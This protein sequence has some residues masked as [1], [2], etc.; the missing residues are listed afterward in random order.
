MSIYYDDKEGIYKH[1]D[2]IILGEIDPED[3]FSSL[4]NEGNKKSFIVNNSIYKVKTNSDRYFLFKQCRSCIVCG[5][6]GTRLFLERYNKDQIPH[7]NL[8]AEEDGDLIVLTKDHIIPKS[9][10]GEDCHSNYQTMCSICNSLKGHYNILIEDLNKIRQF[11]KNK[12]NSFNKKELFLQIEKMKQKFQKKIIVK[13][14]KLKPNYLKIPYDMN[15]YEKNG[16]LYAFHVYEQQNSYVHCGCIKKNTVIPIL[17]NIKNQFL[18]EL[19]KN[20]SILI[21]L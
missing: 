18:C 11:Y 13:D 12:K 3:L 20:N 9:C 5:L 17:L 21:C 6:K 19:D 10:G 4:S 2:K 14:Q 16:D 8:Y 7:F 15:V 1:V